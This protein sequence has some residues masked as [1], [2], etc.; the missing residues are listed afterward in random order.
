MEVFIA[1][2]M[3]VLAVVALVIARIVYVGTRPSRTAMPQEALPVRQQAVRQP[4]TQLPIRLRTP[5]PLQVLWMRMEQLPH[6]LWL[7]ATAPEGD[8]FLRITTYQGVLC[9]ERIPGDKFT[10]RVE[11]QPLTVEY[12]RT[13][14]DATTLTVET[15]VV[16]MQ[17]EDGELRVPRPWET[18]VTPLLPAREVD[19]DLV[20]RLNRQLAAAALW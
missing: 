13:R 1:S 4:T 16:T 20:Q 5:S 14:L 10:D 6:N 9:V 3:V 18:E 12:L 2:A 7:Y 17:A 19:L 8:F 15:G 11:G